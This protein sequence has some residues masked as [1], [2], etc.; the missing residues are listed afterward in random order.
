MRRVANVAFPLAAAVLVT[1]A[2]LVVSGQRF[3]I[4]HL[5]GLSLVVAI[6][7][8]YSLF[9]ERTEDTSEAHDLVIASLAVA[10]LCTI[11]GFG[12]LSFSEIPVL[13][14]I[15]LTVATGAALSL[16]FSAILSERRIGDDTLMITNRADG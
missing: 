15:G 3:T 7:S 12:V 1:A 10:N 6:G 2:I 16:I 14:G 8:N 5:I 13:H 11:I 9:F 4:F